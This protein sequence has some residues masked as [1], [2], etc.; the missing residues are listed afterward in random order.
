VSSLY[1]NT[2]GGN[3]TARFNSSLLL[4][5]TGGSNT[6]IGLQALRNNTTGGNNSALGVQSL[7]SNTTGYSNTAVG[8]YSLQ[9]NTTGHENTAVG[10][11][12][13][14]IN[15]IGSTNTA[16]G[17]LALGGNIT[18]ANNTAIGWGSFYNHDNCFNCTFLGA[19]TNT[20]GPGINNSTAIGYGA[21]VDASN[22]ILLGQKGA[23]APSVFI[24]GILKSYKNVPGAYILS[25]NG[26]GIATLP[27]FCSIPVLGSLYITAGNN[28]YSNSGVLNGGVASGTAVN[29]DDSGLLVI[30]T[31]GYGLKA[32]GDNNY[33]GAVVFD[34][35]N[36]KG[37]QPIAL[38]MTATCSSVKLYSDFNVEV[39][40]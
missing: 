7:Q 34:I 15:T 32:W 9:N 12:A 31:D 35:F 14:Q 19:G 3:N 5:T 23:S 22:Q 29:V 16:L 25:T 21:A 30:I 33:T 28:F 39:N 10:I 1:T 40:L 8:V 36:N 2:S 18:G 11:Q 6:A 27:I 38:Y 17:Y 13:L 26:H 4:N 20:N 24:P 37:G